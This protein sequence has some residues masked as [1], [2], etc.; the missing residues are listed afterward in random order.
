MVR[1]DSA[2][3]FFLPDGAPA[4]PRWALL[5]HAPGTPAEPLARAWLAVQ[6]GIEPD[7]V[8][9][10]RDGRGR[11]GLGDGFA[12]F[13][14]NW[15]HSGDRL[16]VALGGGVRVGV[17]LERLKP[18]PNALALARRFFTSAEAERLARTPEP[19]RELAFARLWCAKEAVLK[20]HGHGL[21]FGL[22]RL[23]FVTDVDRLLLAACDAALGTSVQWALRM[24][25]PERGYVAA[26]AWRPA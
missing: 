8:P 19:D 23:E 16:L 10:Q 1:P 4:A 12:A 9:L 11:P 21:S 2:P 15:S 22:D 26:I 14:C 24:H 6:L 25:A 7:A 13:D 3:D 17:D 20:A 18:R 5:S